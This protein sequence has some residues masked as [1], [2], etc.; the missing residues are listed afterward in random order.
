MTEWKAKRFWTDATVEPVGDGWAVRLDGRPVRTPSKAELVLPSEALARGMAAEWDA[1]Q[2]VIAPLTM[3]LTRAANTTVDKVLPQVEAV[4]D[5]LAGYGATDLLCYRAAAPAGLVERQRAAWDPLLDWAAAAL[6][7]RLA[8]TEGVMAIG[9]PPE[10]LA[11]LRDRVSRTPAWE[12]AA[13]SEFVTISGSLV[14]GL[15]ALDRDRPFPHDLFDRSRVDEDWQIAQWG[16][17]EEEA[18]RTA[19]RRASFDQA[20]RWLELLRR[21]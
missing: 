7:A 13:L 4:V 17:D 10:A 18:A 8:V 16:E 9:Q 11:A 6:G 3:P 1:Q 14:I 21:I 20:G 2:E 15:A 12:L 5:E 19:H